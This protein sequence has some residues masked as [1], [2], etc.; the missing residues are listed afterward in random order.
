MGAL[1]AAPKKVLLLYLSHVCRWSFGS[2]TKSL[3]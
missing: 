1:P 2:A 3:R